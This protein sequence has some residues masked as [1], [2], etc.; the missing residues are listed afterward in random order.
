[1]GFEGWRV[2]QATAGKKTHRQVRQHDNTQMHHGMVSRGLEGA[3]CPGTTQGGRLRPTKDGGWPRWAACAWSH[4][5]LG[6][7]VLMSIGL[8]GVWAACA[9]SHLCLGAAVPISI[10]LLGVSLGMCLPAIR[11]REGG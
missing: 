1:M 11:Q 8:L 6:A 5:C 10:G 7:A 2:A 3:G 4:V 9:W